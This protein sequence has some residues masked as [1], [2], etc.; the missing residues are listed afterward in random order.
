MKFNWS[1]GSKEWEE[2]KAKVRN[3]EQYADD[4][5]G[6]VRTGDL[7]FD[8]IVTEDENETAEGCKATLLTLEYN[9]YTGGIDTGYAYSKTE[10]G[11]EYPY[12]YTEGGDFGNV[13]DMSFEE[14]KKLAEKEMQEYIIVNNHYYYYKEYGYALLLCKADQ[15]LNCW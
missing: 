7:C 2:F 13:F 9:L 3:K 1:I 8:L 15:P 4:C 14:F 6:L 12:D 5:I 10:T 11:E